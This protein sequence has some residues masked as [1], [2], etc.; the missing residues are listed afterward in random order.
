M[1]RASSKLSDVVG[2]EQD[3][4]EDDR[5]HPASQLPGATTGNLRPS[6]VDAVRKGIAGGRGISEVSVSASGT[7]PR[8]SS[9]LHPVGHLG[10][11]HHMH[12]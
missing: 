3:I 10:I 9:L 1:S 5:R 12:G 6:A 11:S 2:S 4:M 8:E 7:I